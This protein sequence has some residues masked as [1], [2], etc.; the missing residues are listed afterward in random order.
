VLFELADPT[1]RVIISETVKFIVPDRMA[2]K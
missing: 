2:A 1:H